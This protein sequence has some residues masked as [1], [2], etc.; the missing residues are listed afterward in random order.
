MTYVYVC[1]YMYYAIKKLAPLSRLC[2]I[3]CVLG[4]YDSRRDVTC[5]CACAR[6][7][8]EQYSGMRRIFEKSF[9][10][11]RVMARGNEHVQQRLF[12]RLDMILNVRG[13]EPKMAEC[14][15]EVRF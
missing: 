5:D 14:L 11:L 7:L 9:T 2:C 15:T 3:L 12:D 13:A 1:V 4:L 6:C 10:L 8:Q